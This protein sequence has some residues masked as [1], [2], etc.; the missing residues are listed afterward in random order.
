MITQKKKA[1]ILKN[2]I[3][4]TIN[5]LLKKGNMKNFIQNLS[6]DVRKYIFENGFNPKW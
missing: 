5:E 3:D 6:K 1:L 2:P 4:L